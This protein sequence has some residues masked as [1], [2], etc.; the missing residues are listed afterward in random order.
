MMD[1]C[2]PKTATDVLEVTFYRRVDADVPWTA[3]AKIGS[4]RA[5]GMGVDRQSALAALLDM[6]GNRTAAG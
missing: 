3:T 5:A 6:L 4:Y 1:I 2:I